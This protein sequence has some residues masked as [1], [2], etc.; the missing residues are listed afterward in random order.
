[1]RYKVGDQEYNPKNKSNPQTASALI[2]TGRAVFYGISVRTDGSNDVT[3]TLYD[4]TSGTGTTILPSSIV[5][6]GTSKFA[7][8]DDDRGISITNGIYAT[9]TSPGTFS[10]QVYYDNN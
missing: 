1:M 3:I 10:Y 4:N 5:I 6:D 7:T 9:V 8:I 2:V